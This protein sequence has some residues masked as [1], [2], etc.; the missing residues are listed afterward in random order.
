MG[1]GTIAGSAKVGN[2]KAGNQGRRRA[3]DPGVIES[4]D[5]AQQAL[6]LRREGF[7]FDAIAEQLG[8][9]DRSGAW[10]AI[11]KLL[12]RRAKESDADADAVRALELERL[13]AMLRALWGKVVKGDLPAIESALH[14]V[15]RRSKL[16]GLDAPAKQEISG[17]GGAPVEFSVLTDPELAAKLIELAGDLVK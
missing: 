12:Q 8:Y 6:A 16:L 7:D 10:K 17:A 4:T 1:L 14:I 5:R 11:D 2:A 15:T 9:A 3:T 13:D